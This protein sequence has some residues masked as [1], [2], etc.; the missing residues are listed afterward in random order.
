[1]AIE[2]VTVIAGHGSSTNIKV[3]RQL[4]EKYGLG[5]WTKIA[6]AINGKYYSYQVHYYEKN[7][8]QYECKLKE[9]PKERKWNYENKSIS[10]WNWWIYRIRI[11]R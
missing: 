9:K 1:M 8:T 4:E 10:K 6:G 11:I 5:N 3:K 7:G 2:N